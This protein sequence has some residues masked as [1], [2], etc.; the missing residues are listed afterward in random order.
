[1]RSECR[2]VVKKEERDERTS[3]SLLYPPS[4]RQARTSVEDRDDGTS[5]EVGSQRSSDAGKTVS[6]WSVRPGVEGR[7][8]RERLEGGLGEQLT[9]TEAG[10]DPNSPSKF[11]HSVG[12]RLHLL[13]RCRGSSLSND[14]VLAV[15]GRSRRSDET[16]PLFLPLVRV[17]RRYSCCE[18]GGINDRSVPLFR[19]LELH[20]GLVLVPLAGSDCRGES[21]GALFSP[22]PPPVSSDCTFARYSGRKEW[23]GD[24]Q[25]RARTPRIARSLASAAGGKKKRDPRI[26]SR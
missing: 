17:D 21:T 19:R 6:A 11:P 20:K 24:S 2:G 8:S 25:R 7:R 15:R 5:R 26:R 18:P 9:G 14:V 16:S 23:E 13:L 22:R 3:C 10:C 4:S 12:C 1:V